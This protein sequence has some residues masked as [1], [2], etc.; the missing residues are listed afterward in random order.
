MAYEMITPKK[1]NYFV[2][3][4]PH[5]TQ[6]ERKWKVNHRMDKY[7][8]GNKEQIFVLIQG[9]CVLYYMP[10]RTL[11]NSGLFKDYVRLAFE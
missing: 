2:N 1:C 7:R 9:Q 10:Q 6:L 5:I 11:L 4:S 3:I 8:L